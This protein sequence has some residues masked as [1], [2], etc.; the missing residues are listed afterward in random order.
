[1]YITP[2]NIPLRCKMRSRQNHLQHCNIQ[3]IPQFCIQPEDGLQSQNI[4][5]MINY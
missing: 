5:L 4:S 3:F 1:M 2:Y